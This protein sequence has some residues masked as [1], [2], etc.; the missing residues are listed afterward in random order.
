MITIGGTME[1]KAVN[2]LWNKGVQM[3][4]QGYS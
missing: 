1:D 3:M 4:G 2:E